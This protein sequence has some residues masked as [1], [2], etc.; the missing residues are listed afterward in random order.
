MITNSP[1]LLPIQRQTHETTQFSMNAPATTAQVTPLASSVPAI[2]TPLSTTP[3]LILGPFYPVNPPP[4]AGA[5]LFSG[6]SERAPGLQPMILSGQVLNRAGHPVPN[7]LVEIWQ[8]DESGR[9]PHASAPQGVPGTASFVAYGALRTGTDGSYLFRTIQPAAYLE[10]DQ[11]RAPHIHFQ[12]TG[13]YDRLITQMFFPDEPLRDN[14]HWFRAVTRP[15]QL[16]AKRVSTRQQPLHL[17]WDIVLRN[18]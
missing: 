15:L 5:D 7:A 11:Q 9:Y 13:Q 12:V 16:V 3:N 6:F 4:D 8:A 2:P 17:Q 1:K 10:N 18:G 14:D